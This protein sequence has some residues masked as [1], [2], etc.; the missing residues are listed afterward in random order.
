M[1]VRHPAKCLDNG[2]WEHL[3][4]SC[5]LLL[6]GFVQALVPLEDESIHVQ[7]ALT[8]S[9]R[10]DPNSDYVFEHNR[11]A[12]ECLALV[13]FLAYNTIHPVLAQS[14]KPARKI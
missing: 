2:A 6:G 12:I 5:V 9:N 3:S 4:L 8:A 1:S 13:A 7:T 10:S 14:L 11:A